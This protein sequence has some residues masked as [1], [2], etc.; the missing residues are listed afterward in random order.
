M[1]RRFD[2]PRLFTVVFLLGG[3]AFSSL[4]AQG[5]DAVIHFKEGNDGLRAEL[6]GAPNEPSAGGSS[7]ISS[8]KWLKIEALYTVNAPRDREVLPEVRFKVYVDADNVKNPRD[9][10][11]DP[12][13]LTGDATYINLPNVPSGS[14]LKVSFY[15]HPYT[16]NRYGGERKFSFTSDRNIHIEALVDEQVVASRDAHSGDEKNWFKNGQATVQGVVLT[17]E[18]SPWA[19]SDMTSYPQAK[20]KSSS[21]N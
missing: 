7:Y 8:K 10:K 13:I 16:I 19:F 21:G 17:K 15:I 20:L 2:F 3:A 4:L 6:I 5:D 12:I 18:Q 9:D 11:G 14:E 1:M